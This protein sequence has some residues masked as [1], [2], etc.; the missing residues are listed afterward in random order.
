MAVTD[1]TCVLDDQFGHLLRRAHQWHQTIFA[2]QL[3]EGLTPFRLA[4]EPDGVSQNALGRMVAM[5]AATTKGGVS[6]PQAR[7]MVQ[8]EADA[9]DKRRY[10]LSAAAASHALLKALLPQMQ[11][12]T[13]GTLAPLTARDDAQLVRLLR[14]MIQAKA[15]RPRFV[16]MQTFTVRSGRARLGDSGQADGEGAR[17]CDRGQIPPNGAVTR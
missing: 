16:G 14:K 6:R 2:R 4:S 9:H 10:T 1:E 17:A 13:A 7:G 8:A 5:D 11:A 3:T 15:P 12:I